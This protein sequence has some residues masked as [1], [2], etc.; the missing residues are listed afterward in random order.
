MDPMDLSSI[1]FFFVSSRIAARPV[2][3]QSAAGPRLL[4]G[5]WDGRWHEWNSWPSQPGPMDV[6]Q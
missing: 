2:P 4:T 5:A 6:D 3:R 1:Q